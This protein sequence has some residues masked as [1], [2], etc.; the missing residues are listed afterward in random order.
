MTVGPWRPI[1]LHAYTSHVKDLRAVIDVKEDLSIRVDVSFEINGPSTGLKASY[2]LL[3]ADKKPLFSD[4]V[5]LASG[6]GH[7]FFEAKS[8]VYDLWYPIG[9]GKQSLYVLQAKLTDEVCIF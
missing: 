9:Y 3:S 2:A 1:S 7:A 6:N 8:G 4:A 5:S